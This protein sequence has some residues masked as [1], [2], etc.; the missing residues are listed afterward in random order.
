VDIKF[1]FPLELRVY[2]KSLARGSY[3]NSDG[4]FLLYL[5]RQVIAMGIV[6]SLEEYKPRKW[7]CIE[8]RY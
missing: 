1:D 7:L 5:Q 3:P 6:T 8:P 2:N 4:R